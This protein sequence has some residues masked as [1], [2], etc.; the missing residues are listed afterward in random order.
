ML[1]CQAGISASFSCMIHIDAQGPG[2]LLIQLGCSQ[3]H[4]NCQNKSPGTS[5]YPC[6]LYLSVPKTCTVVAQKP[7]SMAEGCL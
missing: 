7:N 2:N 4:C 6:L 3:V 1:A 5:E